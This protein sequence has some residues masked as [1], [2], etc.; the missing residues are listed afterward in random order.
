MSKKL[1][2]FVFGISRLRS[3]REDVSKVIMQS[4]KLRDNARKINPQKSIARANRF[5]KLG[6]KRLLRLQGIT[7]ALGLLLPVLSLLVDS[8]TLF[9]LFELYVGVLAIEVYLRNIVLE[10]LLYNRLNPREPKKTLVFKCAWN[11][12]ITKTKVLAGACLMTV[13]KKAFP[14]TYRKIII[15]K[16]GERVQERFDHR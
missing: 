14:K 9:W 16:L 7:L 8:N 15:P 2:D 4:E 5:V 3:V 11:E 1:I 6:K 12:S 13:I 10:I